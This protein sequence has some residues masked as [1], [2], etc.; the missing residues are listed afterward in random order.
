MYIYICYNYFFICIREINSWFICLGEDHE[1]E[2]EKYSRL[3]RTQPTSA[4]HVSFAY[5]V[6]CLILLDHGKLA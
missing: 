3:V 2:E 6:H 4:W 5:D 1:L